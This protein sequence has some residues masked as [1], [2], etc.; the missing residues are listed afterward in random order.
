[1]AYRKKIEE[2]RCQVRALEENVKALDKAFAQE[3]ER[4]RRQEQAQ[5]LDDL[6]ARLTQEVAEMQFLE[7]AASYSF[8]KG[9]LISGL[10]KFA[11]GGAMAT[12]L[13]SKE[14]PLSVGAKLAEY[15]FSR[16]K[17]FKIVAIAVGP[18]GIPRDVLVVSLSRVARE[19]GKPESEVR[20]AL[21]SRG[22]RIMTP[23]DFVQL[24]TE[25]KGKVLGGTATLPF[26]ETRFRI[27]PVTIKLL[28]FQPKADCR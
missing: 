18:K 12:M 7:S 1:M 8:T 9:T 14:H 22:Y 19:T 6:R 26:M 13:H 17:A 25:L 21:E 16:T 24:L 28:E 11:I 10:M 2:L 3:A 5:C 15:E 23:D 4:L 27:K 20:A